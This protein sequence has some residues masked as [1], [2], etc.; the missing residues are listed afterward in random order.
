MPQHLN[1]EA[2]RT[3]QPRVLSERLELTPLDSTGVAAL[4][5]RDAGTLERL[6][7]ARRRLR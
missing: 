4:L 7:G 5:A 6:T 3:S 2:R 1:D